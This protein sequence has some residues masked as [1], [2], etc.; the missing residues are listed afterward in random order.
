MVSAA[1]LLSLRADE[2]ISGPLQRITEIRKRTNDE[3]KVFS[4]QGVRT[5]IN[6]MELGF[7]GH[8]PVVALADPGADGFEHIPMVEIG[9]R[10]ANRVP[11]GRPDRDDHL[12]GTISLRGRS[13]RDDD[14]SPLARIIEEVGRFDHVRQRLQ[15]L[16]A[17]AVEAIARS[18]PRVD[19]GVVDGGQ[20]P[21]VPHH[22]RGLEVVAG[23][24][25]LHD[26]EQV[27]RLLA[28]AA[29]HE[30]PDHVEDVDL[31]RLD[32]IGNVGDL[33]G[34]VARRFVGP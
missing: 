33:A 5:M 19:V 1:Q 27:L 10:A 11:E 16:P 29:L 25:E 22:C 23:D 13:S 15:E 26:V 12:V 18:G 28:E 32:R 24:A 30:R 8:C 21:P 17:I 2:R 34:A 6:E 7:S 3:M 4:G 20:H 14:R 9:D 31:F